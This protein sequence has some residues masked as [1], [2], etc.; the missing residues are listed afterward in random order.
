MILLRVLDLY[1]NAFLYLLSN[2]SYNTNSLSKVVLH[3]LKA[4]R[5]Y[6][7]IHRKYIN[8]SY[9][10]MLPAG[11]IAAIFIGVLFAV[12]VPGMLVGMYCLRM[13]Y[14]RGLYDAGGDEA[15]IAVGRH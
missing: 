9:T 3:V 4:N 10:T 12:V 6:I 14:Y 11:Y 7:I 8:L 5:L 13:G 1:K 2:H 15:I